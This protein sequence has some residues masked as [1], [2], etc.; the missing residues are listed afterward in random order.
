MLKTKTRPLRREA[1]IMMEIIRTR[2]SIRS[3]EPRPVEE[4]KV[5]LLAEAVLRAPTSHN[6]RHWEF[7]FVDDSETLVA[8]ATLK[9]QGSAFL[10]GA[11]LAVAVLGSEETTRIWI[12]DCAIAATFLQLAAQSLGLGSCWIQVRDRAR[13]DS[14]TSEEHVRGLLGIPDTLRV[15][16]VIGVGY[17]AEAKE[18]VPA[19]RLG[20]HK[21][22]RNRY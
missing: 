19:E 6:L 1:S 8:L 13:S 2:R 17:P 9:P 16:A 10:S 12:E 4:E 5:R 14:Q 3:Y 20:R 22:H 7:V 21:I 15:L 11:P 18:P